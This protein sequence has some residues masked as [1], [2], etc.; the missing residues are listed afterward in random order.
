MKA[1]RPG[2]TLRRLLK[3][4]MAFAALVAGAVGLL[5]V[6]LWAGHYSAV[7]L[8]TPTG[9]FAVGRLT[10]AWIDEAHVDPFAPS[11][12][13]RRE[14]VV[15]IW[16]PATATAKAV[17]ASY[18]PEDWR[19]ALE[20]QRDSLLGR[21]MGTLLT[22]DLARVHPHSVVDAAIAGARLRYP[23]VILRPGGGAWTISFT[24]LAEDLASHGYVVVGF[25]A[26]Y[27]TGSVVFPDGRV[28]TRPAAYNPETLSGEAQV[29]LAERLAAAWS[30]DVGFVVDRLEQLNA[31]TGGRFRGRLDLRRLGVVG[32][33]LGGATALQ[34]CH[35]D[36]R[37]RAAV[38]LDGALWGSVV[39]E[40]LHQPVLILLSDHRGE[41]DPQ[42]R[43]IRANLRSLYARLPANSRALLTIRGA[44]HFTFSDQLLIRPP[45]LVWLLRLAGVLRLDP[46]RGLAITRETVRRFLDVHLEGAA[47]GSSPK[48]SYPELVAGF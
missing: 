31:G 25:D 37:C 38:D 6:L 19:R 47:A 9:P 42:G 14:L 23:L 36:A 21:T 4:A 35:D 41:S 27:R 5:L 22:R 16:Y 11:P 2:P 28:V 10:D 1:L 44:N 46:L 33:S 7:T 40:G 12:G 17:P 8:P 43:L 29:K 45:V 15:W 32:H 20:R 39:Q 30:E 34:F 13:A 48:G 26:P 24:T 3:I 18:L